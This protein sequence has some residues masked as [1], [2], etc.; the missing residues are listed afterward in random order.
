MRVRATAVAFVGL[1]WL[2]CATPQFGVAQVSADE[3]EIETETREALS[4]FGSG[5]DSSRVATT[6]A[7]GAV[8]PLVQTRLWVR[9]GQPELALEALESLSPDR[10]GSP[11]VDL[12]RAR[13]GLRYGDEAEAQRAAVNFWHACRAM[14]VEVRR[15]MWLDLVSLMT[16]T[17]SSGWREAATGPESCRVVQD[18]FEE[19]ARLMAVSV[20]NRLALHYRRLDEAERR[21]VINRPRLYEGMSDLFGRPAELWLDDRGLLLV[22]LGEPDHEEACPSV[23]EDL[24]AICWAYYRP[25]GYKLFYLSALR[26]TEQTELMA[27]PAAG[28]G[29]YRIQ[30]SLGP[31]ARLGDSYFHRFVVNSDLLPSVIRHITRSA[32]PEVAVDRADRLREQQLDAAEDSMS[33]RLVQ[34]AT[35]RYTSEAIES[36]PDV[37]AVASS[38]VMRWEA[39]RFFNPSQD[40]WQ[41]WVLASVRADDFERE[42]VKDS[43]VYAISAKLAART[44]NRYA[45]DSLEQRVSLPTGAAKGAGIPVRM[46]LTAEPGPVPFTLAITDDANPGHGAWVQDTV[47]VRSATGLAHLSDVAVA[48][49]EG[50]SWTR[51]GET[52][53]QVTPSHITDP[54]GNIHVYFEV[55]GISAGRDYEVELRLGRTDEP[56]E[57]FALAP[58]ELPFR[59]AFNASMQPSGVGRHHVRLELGETTPGP[60][61]LG[62]RV[63]DPAVGYYTLPS[64]TPIH[65]VDR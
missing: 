9:A 51:D 20:D 23:G 29:D 18:M 49:R 6:L 48:Q 10:A 31:R 65:V 17:E 15:E 40:R 56:A 57:L 58:S 47:R 41:V 39:L 64:V 33:S 25:A 21:Y 12:E 32:A 60:Y 19:R 43:I 55:Y 45:L 22:R 38:A 2:A 34:L 46:S 36:I 44:S 5:P 1:S 24:Q 53:L 13:I 11:A 42:T 37:P 50:G 30:E 8:D 16:P 27:V 61:T 28:D 54:D 52:F 35:H 7:S 26:R 59:L 4:R 14:D 62:I 63:R 3:I